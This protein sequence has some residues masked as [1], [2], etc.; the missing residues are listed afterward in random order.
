M[1]ING[2]LKLKDKIGYG[3]AAIGDS[4]SYTLISIYLLFF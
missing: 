1:R 4:G 2:K 3:V